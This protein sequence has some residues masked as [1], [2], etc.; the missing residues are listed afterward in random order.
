MRAG[1]DAFRCLLAW[2]GC[3][4]PHRFPLAAGLCY[5]LLAVENAK[6]EVQVSAP[7]DGPGRISPAEASQ[8]CP[9]CSQALAPQRCKLIC[10]LCGYYMSCSDYY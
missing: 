2:P 6:L 4:L 10:P 7:A 1:P 9:V 5:N 3:G 8:Y